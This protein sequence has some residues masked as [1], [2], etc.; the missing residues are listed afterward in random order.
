MGYV[1]A[2]P[3]GPP[4]HVPDAHVFHRYGANYPSLGHLLWFARQ[5]HAA[6]QLDRPLDLTTARA[7][8]RPDLYRVAARSLGL[9]C[10]DRDLL[11]EGDHAAP[12]SLE[13][14]Q[15]T[16]AM[17]PDRFLDGARFDPLAG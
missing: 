10:P 5:M 1:Q 3:D 14:P 13:T 2:D 17:G 9:P 8:C 11:P 15:G 4:R 12:W 6:G 7:V 16:I